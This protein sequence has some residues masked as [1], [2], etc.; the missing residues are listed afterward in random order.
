MC[1][2]GMNTPEMSTPEMNTCNRC[3]RLLPADSFARYP[4]GRLR[5]TCRHCRYEMYV[6]RAVRKWR[7]KEK[8]LILMNR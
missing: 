5:C 4:S 2:P 6:V 3:G 1:T 7:M 8:A